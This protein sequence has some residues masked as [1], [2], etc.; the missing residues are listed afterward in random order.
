MKLSVIVPAY[1]EEAL[2]PT[3]LPRIR[4]SL[5]AAS[6][7]SEVI[8]VDNASEDSTAEIA[9]DAGARVIFASTRNIAAVRNA[10][11]AAAA[12]DVVVFIDADTMVPEHLFTAIL[13]ALDDAH[14]YG[15][16]VAVEYDELR[17]PWMKWYLAGWKFWA[18]LFNF[19]QGAAQFTRRQVFAAV[20]GYDE[21]IFMGEDIDFFWRMRRYARRHGGN[22]KVLREPHVVTSGRRF[23]KM[24]LWRVLVLTHPA[25]IRL[26]WRKQRWWKE[27]YEDALR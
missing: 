7:E 11:A 16:A 4:L 13:Q 25:F 6:V 9:R 17:R 12:G 2:L 24:N 14:C 22:V 21:S 26:T 23:N 27:W 20:G 3:T 10:G 18:A 19:A 1:N 5:R 8:V 15:G